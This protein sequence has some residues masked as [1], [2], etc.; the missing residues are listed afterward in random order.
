M[1]KQRGWDLYGAS[2]YRIS[3]WKEL[4]KNKNVGFL[5]CIQE[6]EL[7]MQFDRSIKQ[8]SGQLRIR[9]VQT[10][11]SSPLFW[12]SGIETIQQSHGRPRQY[13]YESSLY[14]ELQEV[15]NYRKWFLHALWLLGR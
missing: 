1:A 5:P 12:L 14:E 15:N 8:V 2:V 4:V 10:N 11:T 6:G 9:E 13:F 3:K 7:Q